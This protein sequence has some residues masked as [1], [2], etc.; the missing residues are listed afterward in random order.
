MIAEAR[1]ARW[2]LAAALGTAALAKWLAFAFDA[3]PGGVPRWPYAVASGVEL[4]LALWLLV[5]RGA[6]WAAAIAGGGFAGAAAST[7]AAAALGEG[8]SCRCLGL[9]ATGPGTALAVQG[10]VV[11]LSGAVLRQR[12]RA[13]EG[14]A[15]ARGSRAK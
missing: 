1:A 13:V 9:V 15:A 4:M 7:A 8:V 10:L 3:W 14:T 11:L 5:G 12:V 2:A 6:V